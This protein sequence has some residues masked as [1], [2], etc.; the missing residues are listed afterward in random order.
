MK[1]RTALVLFLL[2]FFLV[3]CYRDDLMLP[4]GN[5]EPN[6]MPIT[7]RWATDVV[8]AAK[9]KLEA[10]RKAKAKAKEEAKVTAL[11]EEEAKEKLEVAKATVKAEAPEWLGQAEQG[12]AEAQYNLGR[13]YAKEEKY[14]EAV[15][16][17]RKAAEQG[18]ANAQF[19]LGWMY[20][21]GS[22][23]LK[24]YKEAI[25]WWRKAAEQDYAEAYWRLG[26][27][28]GPGYG[29]SKNLCESRYWY[30]KAARGTGFSDLAEYRLRDLNIFCEDANED[31]RSKTERKA[32]IAQNLLKIKA[33]NSCV[34]CNLSRV[35]LI[36]ENLE[37]A[38]LSGAGLIEAN[39]SGANLS[40]AIFSNPLVY[41]RG[42]NSGKM[43]NYVDGTYRAN[44]SGANLTGANLKGATL[45]GVVLTGASLERANLTNADLR[46]A[47]LTNANLTGATIKDAQI[48]GAIF[49]NTKTPWGLDNSG[50]K[51]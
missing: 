30:A 43:A 37:T 27:M 17:Y 40:Y 34:D 23:V 8:E 4:E 12:D 1:L 35:S 19:N 45:A 48:E 11:S 38:N 49:C 15:K 9:V 22:G 2:S 33:L 3:G 41:T 31:S 29:V 32:S 5:A 18:N 16:W 20:S 24:D 6:R 28:Y 42:N 39:L 25:K 51:K 13:E 36:E 10:E 46:K 44:L 21:S 26:L 7:D 47:D 50:C 14:K